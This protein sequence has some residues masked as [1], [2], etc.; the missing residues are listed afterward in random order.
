MTAYAETVEAVRLASAEIGD[1]EWDAESQ[2]PNRAIVAGGAQGV[3]SVHTDKR[4]PGHAVVSL[5]IDGMTREQA[6]AV[7]HA[8]EDATNDR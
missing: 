4:Q 7:L 5:E 8:L 6:V 2:A 3:V 1:G